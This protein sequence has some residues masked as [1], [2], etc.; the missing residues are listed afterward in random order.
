MKITI[1][2]YY[3]KIGAPELPCGARTEY[4]GEAIYG[5]GKTWEGAKTAVLKNLKDLME[6]NVPKREIVDVP[7]PEPEPDFFEDKEGEKEELPF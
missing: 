6:A 4:Q 5:S 1:D 2:Y 3:N 7:E